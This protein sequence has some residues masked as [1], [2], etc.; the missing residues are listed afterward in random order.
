MGAKCS[1]GCELGEILLRFV[2]FFWW[3]DK[4]FLVGGRV[5]KSRQISYCFSKFG[6]KTNLNFKKKH[7]PSMDH[8]SF[9]KTKILGERPGWWSPLWCHFSPREPRDIRGRSIR[10][11][12][13]TLVVLFLLAEKAPD[14]EMGSNHIKF[15]MFKWCYPSSTVHIL[16]LHSVSKF[17]THLFNFG[18]GFGTNLYLLLVCHRFRSCSGE[19]DRPSCAESSSGCSGWAYQTSWR[20]CWKK[21]CTSW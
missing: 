19:L 18:C 13:L 16:S 15:P 9:F 21:S 11:G 1:S 8:S 3:K 7:Q 10:T 6:E 17:K 4:N 2:V 14:A 12:D 20:Y 5:K